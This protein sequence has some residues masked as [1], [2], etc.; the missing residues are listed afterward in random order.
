MHRDIKPMNVLIDPKTKEI[1]IIDWG[2]ADLYYPMKQYSCKVSTMRYK[3]PELLIGYHF[4]DYGVDI[5]GIGCILAEMLFGHDFIT[6][7]VYEEVLE[8]I[9]KI[10]SKKPILDFSEKYG[11]EILPSFMQ[12][13]DHCHSSGWD[14][15][16]NGLKPELRNNDMIDLLKKLLEVDLGERIT[17]REALSHPFFRPLFDQ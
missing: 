9:A 3:A 4:Y 10:W 17:A 15:W 12:K 1:S 5:W 2:L 6:G 14:I 7:L 13:I 11:I 16:I 8:S